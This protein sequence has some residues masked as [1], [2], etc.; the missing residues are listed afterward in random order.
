MCASSFYILR[1]LVFLSYFCDGYGVVFVFV[2]VGDVTWWCDDVIRWCDEVTWWYVTLDCAMFSLMSVKDL[3]RDP[4][5]S[6]KCTSFS[7]LIYL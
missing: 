1:E 2:A 3:P 7:Q 6:S 5:F 4:S